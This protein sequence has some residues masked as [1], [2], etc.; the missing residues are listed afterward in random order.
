MRTTLSLDDGLIKEL[1]K[2]TGA[3]TKTEAIHLAISE[4]IRRKKVEGL[5]ALEGKVHLDLDWRELEELELKAQTEHDG[6]WRG[7]R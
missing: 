4:F 3:K 1:M 6:R 5:L 2:V 7:H